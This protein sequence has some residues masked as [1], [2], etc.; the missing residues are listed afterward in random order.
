MQFKFTQND[1]HHIL[2]MDHIFV[3]KVSFV[4]YLFFK[5]WKCIKMENLEIFKSKK[6]LKLWCVKTLVKHDIQ[7]M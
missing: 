2:N 5:N 6:T 1:I 3:W 4:H 7:K